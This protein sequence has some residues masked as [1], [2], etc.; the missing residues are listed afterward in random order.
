MF[1][2]EPHGGD[3]IGVKPTP[4]GITPQQQGKASFPDVHIFETGKV[5]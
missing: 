5:N 3:K 2:K 4:V 1:V